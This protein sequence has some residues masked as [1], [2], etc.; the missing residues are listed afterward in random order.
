[1]FV[2]CIVTN[3]Q[4]DS[5]T[6]RLLSTERLP[7][8]PLSNSSGAVRF[9]AMRTLTIC[10]AL[11]VYSI[12]TGCANR[13][14]ATANAPAPPPPSA[15]AASV[16]VAPSPPAHP[17]GTCKSV[18]GYPDPTCTP[19]EV[20]P[21]VTQSNIKTTICVSGYTKTVRP[22]TSYTDALKI[23]QI[24]E[25][26]YTDTNVADYEEDHFIPLELGGSPS[27][28]RNLWPEFPHSP[29]PKDSVETKLKGLVCANKIT[30][31]QA[32]QLIR[33]DWKTALQK[34]STK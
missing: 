1:M 16:R 12:T 5:P 14:S 17:A 4:S 28:P 19:G 21:N 8:R 7:V 30:L 32:R 29:N 24:G 9:T 10:T 25:Y 6:A 3:G 31:D 20:D 11:A 33:T 18:N 23:Q 15:T 34:A 22:P 26:G 13:T 27:D 2:T